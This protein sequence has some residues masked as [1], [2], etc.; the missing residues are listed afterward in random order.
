MTIKEEVLKEVIEKLDEWI[1]YRGGMSNR[2][3]ATAIRKWLVDMLKEN[4]QVAK[5]VPIKKIS[6]IITLAGD[7]INREVAKEL[8]QKLRGENGK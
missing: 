3:D 5:D 1:D 7:D 8:K 6:P 4:T 2:I